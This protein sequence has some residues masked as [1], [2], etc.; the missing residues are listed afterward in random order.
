M[1]YQLCTIPTNLSCT[2]STTIPTMLPTLHDTHQPGGPR[3]PPFP[4]S[5]RSSGRF[6]PETSPAGSPVMS[7]R[8]KEWMMTWSIGDPVTVALIEGPVAGRIVRITEDTVT[9]VLP[10]WGLGWEWDP[11]VGARATVTIARDSPRLAP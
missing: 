11:A 4:R 10:T 9:V 5:P 8:K 1:R 6:P 7:R 2:I 3:P